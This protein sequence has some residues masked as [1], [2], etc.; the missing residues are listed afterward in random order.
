MSGEKESGATAPDSHC[1]G[2]ERALESR[3]R[4]QRN[5]RCGSYQVIRR[6]AHGSVGD[7]PA[8]R[9]RPASQGNV[10]RDRSSEM[11]QAWSRARGLADVDSGSLRR[12]WRVRRRGHRNGCGSDPRGSASN[13]PCIAIPPFWKRGPR[14][15]LESPVRDQQVLQRLCHLSSNVT[16]RASEGCGQTACQHDCQNG[17]VPSKRQDGPRSYVC[18]APTAWFRLRAAPR[19]DRVEKSGAYSRARR[20]STVREA[21]QVLTAPR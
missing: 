20:R 6:K 8:A 16:L 12:R 11:P 3:G 17:T 15:C 9:N 2:T 19:G 14:I 4:E 5:C 10:E 18:T 13:K 1:G 7:R 21:P